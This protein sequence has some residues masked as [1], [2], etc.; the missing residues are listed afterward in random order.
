MALFT[1]LALYDVQLE[2]KLRLRGFLWLTGLP[3]PFCCM[4][5]ALCFLLKGHFP[6]AIQLHTLRPPAALTIASLG[7]RQTLPG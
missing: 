5:R 6:Q 2:R 4:T 1:T 3:C 7:V